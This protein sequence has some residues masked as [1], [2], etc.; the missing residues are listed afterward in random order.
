MVSEFMVMFLAGTDT[1]SHVLHNIMLQL[2]WYPEVKDKVLQEMRDN[3]KDSQHFDFSEI[4]RLKYLDKVIKET[5]R[6]NTPA[7]AIVAR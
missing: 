2:S 7:P 5:L 6:V 1:T 3:I 4:S